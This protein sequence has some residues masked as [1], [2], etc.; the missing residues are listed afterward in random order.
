MSVPNIQ[1]WAQEMLEILRVESFK[2]VEEYKARSQ[3]FRREISKILASGEETPM[4]NVISFILQYAPRGLTGAI[5]WMLNDVSDLEKLLNETTEK[6]TRKLHYPSLYADRLTVLRKR[7]K[8]L[9]TIF[10]KKVLALMGKCG[11]SAKYNPSL[12]GALQ[13][14]DDSF[15][16]A[17]GGS[18]KGFNIP[19]DKNAM[20]SADDSEFYSTESGDDDKPHVKEDKVDDTAEVLYDD[21]PD[22]YTIITEEIE[23][24]EEN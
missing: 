14:S 15:G 21:E 24:N 6:I 17:F 12:W 13:A 5:S 10:N 7:L 19:F 18:D 11:V 23:N 4:T 20:P 2:S 8:G 3:Q 1:Q 16:D 9:N 22:E